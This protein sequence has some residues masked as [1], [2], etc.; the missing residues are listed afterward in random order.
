MILIPWFFYFMV[1]LKFFLVMVLSAFHGYLS[2]AENTFLIRLIKT[3]QNFTEFI[4]EIPTVILILIVL[5]AVY[6]PIL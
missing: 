5:L 3:V 1:S 2:S 6:K 4:N